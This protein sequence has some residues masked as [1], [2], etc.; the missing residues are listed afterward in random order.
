MRDVTATIV[1]TAISPILCHSSLVLSATVIDL[2]V[3]YQNTASTVEV[4]KTKIQYWQW[5]SSAATWRRI[6]VVK[7]GPATVVIHE[8]V[9]AVANAVLAK[10]AGNPEETSTLELLVMPFPFLN[11][12]QV[13]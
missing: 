6:V 4:C 3:T 9:S 8:K 13:T 10:V 1:R 11:S 12:R 5:S 7:D 2:V